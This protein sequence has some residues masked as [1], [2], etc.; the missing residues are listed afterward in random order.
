[1]F[2]IRAAHLR[3]LGPKTSVVISVSSHRPTGKD[4]CVCTFYTTH[5]P[6]FL[7]LR[8]TAHISPPLPSLKAI[9]KSGRTWMRPMCS[10]SHPILSFPTFFFFWSAFNS[11][12]DVKGCPCIFFCD[13][14]V[15]PPWLSCLA[16]SHFSF[17][18]TCFPV[19]YLSYINSI[20]YLSCYY[21]LK[22]RKTYKAT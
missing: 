3:D 20:S 12:L 9:L 18:Q 14:F 11:S 17:L 6:G 7:A 2:K 8:I 15:D 4:T 10:A 21:D 13:C 16:A 5:T 1:M 22:K 19:I